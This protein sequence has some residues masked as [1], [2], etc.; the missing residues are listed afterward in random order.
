MLKIQRKGNG[1]VILTLSGRIE[2]ENID[3][4]RT[5]LEL[6]E[7]GSHTALDLTDVT[8][9]DRDAVKFLADCEANCINLENCPRYVRE[10]IEQQGGQPRRKKQNARA[11]RVQKR[12]LNNERE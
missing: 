8:L 1:K 2:A 5:L 11:D 7:A 12:E 4:L 10:Q 9:I 6:D 3:E